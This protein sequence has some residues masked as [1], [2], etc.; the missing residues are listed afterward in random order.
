MAYYPKDVEYCAVPSEFKQGRSVVMTDVYPDGYDGLGNLKKGAYLR[1]VNNDKEIG[2]TK[3]WADRGKADDLLVYKDIKAQL[4]EYLI[5]ETR[6]GNM[7]RIAFHRARGSCN[8]AGIIDVH[9]NRLN[10]QSEGGLIAGALIKARKDLELRQKQEI[11]LG[12][13]KT[14]SFRWNAK[15]KLRAL[16]AIEMYGTLRAAA[17][18]LNVDESV[19]ESFINR[20][21]IFANQVIKAK[22]MFLHNLEKTALKLATGVERNVYY[23]GK[24]IGVQTEVNDKVLLKTLAVYDPNKWGD[25]QQV[26]VDVNVKEID[27]SDSAKTKLAAMLGLESSKMIAHMTGEDDVLEADVI[28]DA[29][30][31]PVDIDDYDEELSRYN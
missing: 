28:E 1:S 10:R 7:V 29:E 20:N 16:K 5:T 19:V 24:V 14:T 23:K 27:P 6:N 4:V 25:K 18:E 8:P 31:V 3:I 22:N 17:V 21:A 2:G 15:R 26:N 9:P 12:K 13:R 30:Y 11:A